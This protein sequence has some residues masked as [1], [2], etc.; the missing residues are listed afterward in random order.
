MKRKGRRVKRTS[1]NRRE[2][3]IGRTN[4]AATA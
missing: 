2:T 3:R 1:K 4:A